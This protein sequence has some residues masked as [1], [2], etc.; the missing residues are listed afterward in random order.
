MCVCVC[1]CVCAC[2]RVRVMVLP[3]IVLALE[4]VR[5]KCQKHVWVV[6]F[7]FALVY[8]S[9]VGTSLV[10]QKAYIWLESTRLNKNRCRL[11][12][13]GVIF[14]G[15]LLHMHGY[16]YACNMCAYAYIDMCVCNIWF[17]T[18]FLLAIFVY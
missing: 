10:T 1:V 8:M 4:Y 14:V 15:G 17:V 16:E 2:A 5:Q 18:L 7:F 9:M 13:A 11:A 12:T 3:F 6:R